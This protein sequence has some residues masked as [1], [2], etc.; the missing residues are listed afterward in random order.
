MSPSA[1]TSASTTLS[2]VSPC[3]RMSHPDAAT[4]A[5][6]ADA[7]AASRCRPWWPDCAPVSRGRHR[8][9]V[10][11]RG[12][13]QVLSTRSTETARIA[14]R[15]ITIPSS[16]TVV[17]ATL[18][19]GLRLVRRSR[20]RSRGRSAPLRPRRRRPRSGRSWGSSVDR[21]V[22]HKPVAVTMMCSRVITPPP[23]PRNLHGG[24]CRHRSSSGGCMIAPSGGTEEKPP[25]WT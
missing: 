20:G 11:H 21:A 3:L 22:P 19:L 5:E 8:P 4:Q 18:W 2:T 13:G 9:T 17:P 15:S 14:A 12:R 10:R 7:G 25:I 6:A 1:T 24:S 23:E 16:H